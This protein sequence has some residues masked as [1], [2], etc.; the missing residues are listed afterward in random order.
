MEKTYKEQW[1]EDPELLKSLLDAKNVV[2]GYADGTLY[3]IELLTDGDY[4]VSADS[5]CLTDEYEEFEV[6]EEELFSEIGIKFL[7]PSH[8]QPK[9]LEYLENEEDSGEFATQDLWSF[10]ANCD[11]SW[12]IFCGKKFFIS[13]KNPGGNTISAKESIHKWRVEHLKSML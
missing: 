13:G 4:F 12:T 9:Q 8:I 5:G 6:L 1:S 7:V 2:I 10:E 3:S 11:G